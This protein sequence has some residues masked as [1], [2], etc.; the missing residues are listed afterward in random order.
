[1]WQEG[2]FTVNVLYQGSRS[3]HCNRIGGFRGHRLPGYDTVVT[4]FQPLVCYTVGERESSGFQNRHWSRCYCDF[5]DSS[6][7]HP[8]LYSKTTR[9]DAQ[10]GEWTVHRISQVQILRSCRGGLHCQESQPLPTRT[11]GDRSP[12]PGSESQHSADED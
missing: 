3:Y 1:M 9:E 12:W 7:K 4:G 5:Q 6:S 2:S 10:W 11:S 8:S